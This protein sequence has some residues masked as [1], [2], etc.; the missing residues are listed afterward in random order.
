M[1]L[2]LQTLNKVV[3]L[4]YRVFKSG[5]GRQIVGEQYLTMQEENRRDL[6]RER[7]SHH[8]CWL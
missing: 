3:I 5:R 2:S 1:E 8:H 4:D 7:D 6:K